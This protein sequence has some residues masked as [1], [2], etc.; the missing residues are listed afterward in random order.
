MPAKPDYRR[1]ADEIRQRITSGDL[2][3]DS[4]LPTK[5]ELAVEYGVSVGTVNAALLVLS[6]EGLVEGHQGRGTFVR[7]RSGPD[8]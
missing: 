3:P 8:T 4:K 5:R 2:A 7:G 6:T 1:I